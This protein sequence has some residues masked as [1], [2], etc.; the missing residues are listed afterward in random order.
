[1]EGSLAR[2]PRNEIISLVGA[3][4]RYDLGESFGP[5]LSGGELIGAAAWEELAQA[6]LAYGP[7]EGD[8]R[9]RQ[10]IADQHGVGAD[11]VVVTVGGA[12]ALFLA[13][14]ILCGPGDEAVTTAPVFPHTRTAL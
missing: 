14:F 11:D 3:A 5:N 6:A 8:A 12:Q 1:M 9:L 10:A 7:A 13:A 4:P 2:F